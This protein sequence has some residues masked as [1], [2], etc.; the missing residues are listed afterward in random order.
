MFTNQIWTIHALLMSPILL[1]FLLASSA[2]CITHATH[3]WLVITPLSEKPN[4]R[5]PK[6]NSCTRSRWLVGNILPC[7]NLKMFDMRETAKRRLR[8]LSQ[9][10]ISNHG[11]FYAVGMQPLQAPGAC[12]QGLQHGCSDWSLIECSDG[13]CDVHQRGEELDMNTRPTQFACVLIDSCLSRVTL[14]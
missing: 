3:C 4:L 7:A 8:Y 10:D 12:Y 5:P 2:P 9:P 11:V 1:D 6:E 13:L 14:W